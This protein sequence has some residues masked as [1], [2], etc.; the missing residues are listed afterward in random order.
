MYPIV[1]GYGI[2]VPSGECEALEFFLT[3][4]LMSTEENSV[5]WELDDVECR[6][7]VHVV[8]TGLLITTSDTTV[9]YQLQQIPQPIPTA[10]TDDQ[11]CMAACLRYFTKNFDV[12]AG[13]YTPGYVLG[14]FT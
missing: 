7:S 12:P 3:A 6:I 4:H 9:T 1:A 11:A 5:V 10:T 2:Y 14:S 8:H 13:K